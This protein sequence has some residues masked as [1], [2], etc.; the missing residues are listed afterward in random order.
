M[1]TVILIKYNIEFYKKQSNFKVPDGRTALSSYLY[2]WRTANDINNFLID[3]NLALSGNYSDIE[4]PNYYYDV[5]DIN[6]QIT[7]EKLI[8]SSLNGS[9]GLQIP[10]DDFKEILTS[11]REFL[12][13]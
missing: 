12:F 1:N 8:L 13:N 4:D 2:A 5:L 9:N 7:P 11:W 6:G 10:L 3:I